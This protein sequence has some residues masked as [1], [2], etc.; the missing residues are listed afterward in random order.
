MRRIPSLPRKPC[1]EPGC[2]TATPACGK[3]ENPTA[4]SRSPKDSPSVWPS[5]EQPQRILPQSRWMP[6]QAKSRLPSFCGPAGEGE[7][8]PS[9]RMLLHGKGTGTNQV[10]EGKTGCA[11]QMCK[12]DVQLNPAVPGR[13]RKEREEGFGTV[14]RTQSLESHSTSGHAEGFP[15]ARCHVTLET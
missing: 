15:C 8:H 7:T 9:S 2:H 6:L 14:S 10:E 1:S 5:P 11:N 4:A 3:E 13:Y 12:P